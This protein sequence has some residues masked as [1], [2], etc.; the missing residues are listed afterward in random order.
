MGGSLFYE[1]LEWLH[2]HKLFVSTWFTQPAIDVAETQDWYLTL[3]E[4]QAVLTANCYLQG[5]FF[6][7]L[8]EQDFKK[9]GF[10]IWI[11]CSPFHPLKRGSCVSI[12]PHHC[13]LPLGVR[14]VRKERWMD[15][16][17]FDSSSVLL[18]GKS[19]HVASIWSILRVFEYTKAGRIMARKQNYL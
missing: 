18:K 3:T 6:I 4:C 11:E 5:K 2:A 16:N 7:Y 1:H 19:G 9:M 8:L 13:N 14:G 10:K 12:A 17:A 15:F